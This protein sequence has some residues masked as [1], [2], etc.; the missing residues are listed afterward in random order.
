MKKNIIGQN[1]IFMFFLMI[2]QNYTRNERPTLKTGSAF[3]D[4]VNSTLDATLLEKHKNLPKVLGR[5][6]IP[7]TQKTGSIVMDGINKILDGL[8]DEPIS[9]HQYDYFS[10]KFEEE[11]KIKGAI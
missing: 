1:I 3:L 4:K 10:D 2:D 6:L 7:K 9:Y 11:G 8:L 5:I